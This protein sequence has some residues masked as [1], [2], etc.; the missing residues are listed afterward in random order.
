MRKRPASADLLGGAVGGIEGGSVCCTTTA[1]RVEPRA[2]KLE[3]A[4][5]GHVFDPVGGK[6]FRLRVSLVATCPERRAAAA[7]WTRASC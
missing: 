2:K 4:A 6:I 3:V 7:D 5:L 1:A